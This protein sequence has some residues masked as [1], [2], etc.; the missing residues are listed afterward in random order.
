MSSCFHLRWDLAG[1]MGG[2]TCSHALHVLQ[3]SIFAGRVA[4]DDALEG[5]IALDVVGE[6]LEEG[7]VTD[8]GGIVGLVGLGVGGFVCAV[9]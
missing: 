3:Q 9:G 7:L 1:R 8:G 2:S 4:A 6:T 5:L